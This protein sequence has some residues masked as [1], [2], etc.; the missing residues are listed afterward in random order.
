MQIKNMALKHT[1]YFIFKKTLKLKNIDEQTNKQ[2]NKQKK[3]ANKQITPHKQKA[4][5]QE[6]L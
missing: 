6:I 5:T 1:T 2:T 4:K 3:Q